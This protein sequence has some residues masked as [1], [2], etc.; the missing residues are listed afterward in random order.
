MTMC[1]SVDLRAHGHYPCPLP[2][3]GGVLAGILRGMSAYPTKP[4]RLPS[5][6]LAGLIFLGS[7]VPGLVALLPLTLG[8][9][10]Y[11]SEPS[12][13]PFLTVATV[14]WT[15]A[16]FSIAIAPFLLIK[17]TAR[18][19]ISALG[20]KSRFCPSGAAVAC[21]TSTFSKSRDGSPT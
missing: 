8:A 3:Q 7:L 15:L 13:A 20:S 4:S 17:V 19:S 5:S 18:G 12:N 1:G 6:W 9:G 10:W 16:E 21:T 14:W 2:E 11:L